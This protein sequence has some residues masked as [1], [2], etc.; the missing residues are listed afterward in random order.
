MD[1]KS[2]TIRI[3]RKW[4]RAA[5]IAGVLA[6]VMAPLAAV[7][8]HSFTDVP[9]DQTFHSDIE[10]LKDTGVTRG[11]NPPEN[12]EFCPD[13]FTSRGEM[14]A[15]MQRYAEFIDAEDGTPG[16]ADNADTVDGLDASS[17]VRAEGSATD[18]PTVTDGAAESV[19]IDAPV[20]GMLVIDSV[21]EATDDDAWFCRIDLDGT[22]APELG[23]NI[24]VQSDGNES[25]CP[26]SMVLAV[27]AGEHTVELVV[28]EISTS[29]NE[30]SLSVLFVPFDGNGD[31]PT[32]FFEVTSEDPVDD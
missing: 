31:Q 14:A 16:Q 9:D 10:W 32:T 2:L 11:C 20:D 29:L 25:A 27:E 15:F 17:L 1:D 30:S 18:N 12:T 21:T 26:N 23:Y 22:Q 7:A 3:P 4:V 6:L 28:G 8:S 24:D 19:T 5:M 13:R